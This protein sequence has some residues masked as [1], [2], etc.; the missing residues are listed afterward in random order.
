MKRADAGSGVG[1]TAAWLRHLPNLLTGLRIALIP[2]FL[3]HAHWSAVALAAGASDQPHRGLAVA[4][5]FGIGISDVLDGFIARRFGLATQ[6]GAVLDAVA[7]KLAQLSLLTFFLL[8][9]GLA[10]APVPWWF[11]AVVIGR[12]LI[13]MLG[14][15]I[16]RHQVGSVDV[17]HRAHGR[18]ATVLLFILL[19]CI[20]GDW[21]GRSLV[22]PFMLLLSLVIL[23]STLDYIRQGWRQVHHPVQPQP[24][25]ET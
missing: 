8:S 6:F 19:V 17:V 2:A 1:E 3:C 7:D 21:I 16:V 14:M 15:L 13:M 11:L 10:F 25:S 12:D 20:T 18:V 24:G 9:D 23:I 4:A 22:T 5:L